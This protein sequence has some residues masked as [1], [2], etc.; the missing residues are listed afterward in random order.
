MFL[1]ECT[2]LLDILVAYTGA[3]QLTSALL[4]LLL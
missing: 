4:L 3:L 2:A 1:I